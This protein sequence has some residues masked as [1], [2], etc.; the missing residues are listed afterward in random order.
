MF[1]RSTNILVLSVALGLSSVAFGD[2]YTVNCE[3]P[4][5]STTGTPSF[6]CPVRHVETK[7]GLCKWKCESTVSY[8][9]WVISGTGVGAITGRRS[10]LGVTTESRKIT[11]SE[12]RGGVCTGD[13][14]KNSCLSQLGP[15][16]SWEVKRQFCPDETKA[17]FYAAGQQ[18][19]PTTACAYLLPENACQVSSCS[20][21]YEDG[22][23]DYYG[24]GCG[25]PDCCGDSRCSGRTGTPDFACYAKAYDN[26]NACVQNYQN[27][28]NQN[29]LLGPDDC[30]CIDDSQYFKLDPTLGQWKCQPC[31]DG[32]V[33]DRQGGGTSCK[34]ICA[35]LGPNYF[36]D[37]T[38]PGTGTAK[39][40]TCSAPNVVRPTSSGTICAP[41]CL[42]N[43]VRD[44]TSPSGC[45]S[46]CPSGM[47]A[48]KD[49]N[50]NLLGCACDAAEFGGASA[51]RSAVQWNT[52][53]PG[54]MGW[55]MVTGTASSSPTTRCSCALA[56]GSADVSAVDSADVIS[57]ATVSQ[58]NQIY[59]RV[60][61]TAAAGST[62]YTCGCPNFNEVFQLDSSLGIY[63]CMPKVS[64]ADAVLV[65]YDQSLTEAENGVIGSSSEQS[66][67]KS[68]VLRSTQGSGGVDLSV[69]YSRRVW[70]CRTG[71]VRNPV[72]GVCESVAN[73]WTAQN[74]GD[75]GV[76]DS[77]ETILGM[78]P[79]VNWS[80][81]VNPLLACCVADNNND[82][83]TGSKF[84]CASSA[85]A[86]NQSFDSYY[87]APGGTT[88][89]AGVA[90]PNRLFLV[91]GQTPPQPVVGFFRADGT[92]SNFADSLPRATLL[93][94]LSQVAAR[95][96]TLANRK[97]PLNVPAL[98]G[99]TKDPR[100][101]FMVRAASS[102]SCD[103]AAS[104]ATP[105]GVLRC[106]QAREVRVHYDVI[107]LADPAA[108]HRTA[109]RTL[110]SIGAGGSGV[111]TPVDIK[112][113]LGN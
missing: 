98:N 55:K 5:A 33:Q 8:T 75:G 82:P 2:Q 39:C 63:R 59:G 104:V 58:A 86:P 9:S 16:D 71:T 113:L 24:T 15:E 32:T 74:C 34:S 109:L 111:P 13:N 41:E 65:P 3:Y 23:C 11:M 110:S 107:D 60:A 62:N 78:G 88:D 46:A 89:T 97:D 45:K 57:A 19:D 29:A 30:Y 50:G 100:V 72:T 69:S 80:K 14:A 21:T 67:M 68:A 102:F 42:A 37:P 48:K 61:L 12:R 101:K 26:Y 81:V 87:D 103:P 20:V 93:E 94:A 27:Q 17:K 6:S 77:K 1:S 108:E 22:F 56:Q 54:R 76:K 112:K 92:R 25:D 83:L 95:V 73:N 105:G 96:S 79:G 35:S 44:P 52:V 28:N 84:Q 51:P 10:Y 7:S 18:I 31:P 38:K 49:A 66:A 106:A 64:G 90:H 85:P 70:K 43:E 53:A 91:D 99:L 4:Y 40:S 47:S 36:Y